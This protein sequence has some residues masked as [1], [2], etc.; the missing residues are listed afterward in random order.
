MNGGEDILDLPSSLSGGAEGVRQSPCPET[1]EPMSDSAVVRLVLAGGTAHFEQLVLRYEKPIYRHVFRMLGNVEDAE[2]LTQETFAGAYSNLSRYDDR[3][4]FRAWLYRIATN[5]AITALRKR[6]NHQ[7][8]DDPA[9]FREAGGPPDPRA[10]SPRSLAAVSETLWRLEEAM[11]DISPLAR[12]AFNLRYSEEMDVKEI[13]DTLDRKPGAIAVLLHRTRRQLAG[14]L[15]GEKSN[16]R[17]GEA[18]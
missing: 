15:F 5:T 11:K 12:A 1:V 13:A 9:A 18:S 8:L 7:S 4:P 3:F 16:A 14:R 10:R 17:N 6:R 2:D